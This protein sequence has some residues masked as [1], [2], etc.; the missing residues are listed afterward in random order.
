MILNLSRGDIMLVKYLGDFNNKAY[1][2]NLI[3]N[4]IYDVYA[5]LIDLDEKDIKYILYDGDYIR[6]V[7]NE[8]IEILDEKFISGY[9]NLDT[10]RNLTII[11]EYKKFD[12]DHYYNLID[13]YSEIEEKKAKE[14]FLREKKALE[15]KFKIRRIEIAIL[16]KEL[17]GELIEKDTNNTSYYYNENGLEIFYQIDNKNNISRLDLLND[18]RDEKNINGILF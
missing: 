12:Y 18:S 14:K 8:N 6:F 16:K 17:N 11:S 13:R 10:A 7:R 5:I 2:F 3:E 15:Y 9:Y 4:K 1:S